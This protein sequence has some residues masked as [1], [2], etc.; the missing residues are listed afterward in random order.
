MPDA[1]KVYIT[2]EDVQRLMRV[3]EL[4]RIPV[5]SMEVHGFDD[6]DPAMTEHKEVQFSEKMYGVS[7]WV[8]RGLEPGAF[9]V[10]PAPRFRICGRIAEW[11]V[12]KDGH[13]PAVLDVDMDMGKGFNSPRMVLDP[14][15]MA[16]KEEPGD[17]PDPS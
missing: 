5:E 4:Q 9:R 1:E 8:N 6:F 17:T 14:K 2:R 7:V 16:K 11:N 12:Q 3:L 13:V 15:I 10:L